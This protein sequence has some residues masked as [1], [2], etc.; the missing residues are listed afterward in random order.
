MINTVANS[1]ARN[2]S[3][4]GAFYVLFDLS[5]VYETRIVPFLMQ[6]AS[7]G[8]A[9]FLQHEERPQQFSSKQ[10][11]YFTLQKE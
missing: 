2:T 3:L 11:I 9:V 5:Q 4:C 10:G 7:S 6:R 1:L 8:L